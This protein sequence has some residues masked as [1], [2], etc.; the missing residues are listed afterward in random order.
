LGISPDTASGSGNI[1]ETL[2]N[3]LPITVNVK[4]DYI[5][6]ANGCSIQQNV[7]LQVNPR[8]LAPAITTTAASPVCIGT[9]YQN[10]S[11]N[12]PSDSTLYQWGAINAK[13]WAQ[14]NNGQNALIN[15]PN[16]GNAQIM[17]TASFLGS[18]CLSSDSLSVD[19][20]NTGNSYPSLFY[21]LYHFVCLP[22]NLDAYQWGYDDVATL[23]ATTLIGEINQ[24]YLEPN[25]DYEH[26]YYWVNTSYDGCIQK[27][28]FKLPLNMDTL[29]EVND[30][31]VQ[32][33]PNP[34][35]DSLH[36]TIHTTTSS[37]L[38]IVIINALGEKMI[39]LNTAN[40][41]EV[42]NVA[43]YTPGLYFVIVYKSGEKL[44]AARFVK[45]E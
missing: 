38:K 39:T 7:L 8:P 33:Y 5:L 14:S 32:I 29:K 11:V 15:F 43:S 13:V 2:T 22:N 36:I 40:R 26:K 35:S 1:S 28:Y 31:L 45:D 24:D 16:A 21:F 27:T 9:L 25:P 4:Y 44:A 17:L 10:F 20:N 34:A 18:P 42:V 23:E 37:E 3:R 19:I 12:N 41:K 30:A 6:E